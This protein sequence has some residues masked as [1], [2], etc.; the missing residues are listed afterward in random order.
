M[1]FFFTSRGGLGRV[2]W[3]MCQVFNKLMLKKKKKVKLTKEEM[4]ASV[5]AV[6]IIE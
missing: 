3:G 1:N 6:S 5:S 4:D 2:V